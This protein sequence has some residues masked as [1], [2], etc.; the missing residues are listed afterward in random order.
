MG[1]FNKLEKDN[2]K[3][4]EKAVSTMSGMWAL[5]DYEQYKNIN[6]LEEWEKCF[7]EDEDILKQIDISKIIP[8][9]IHSDGCFQFRIKINKPLD[10]RESK[11]V[12]VK[13]N[14]YLLKSNGTTILSGIE[15]I[16]CDV[17]DDECIKF[18]LNKGLYT[19]VVY[20]IEWDAEPNMKLE[21]GNPA[22]NA[23]P[24][25]II[26]IN[27]SNNNKSYRKSLETFDQ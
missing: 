3:I 12:L 16:V 4:I 23:L 27:K 15:N 1:L 20:L 21:N 2:Y 10:E 22:P 11:Y 8:I 24:D 25:F 9:N 5:W 13:S 18:E 26:S 7:L 17:R 19:I 6:S 14:E